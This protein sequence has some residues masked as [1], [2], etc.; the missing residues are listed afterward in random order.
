MDV[1]SKYHF[2]QLSGQFVSANAVLAPDAFQ[3]L[4]GIRDDD[5]LRR[6]LI[7]VMK[8]IRFRVRK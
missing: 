6:N 2:I 3:L 8:H 5:G 7:F 4:N 1:V